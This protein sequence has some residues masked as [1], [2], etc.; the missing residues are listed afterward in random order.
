MM[1]IFVGF[2]VLTLCLTFF[3]CI[4]MSEILTAYTRIKAF[5]SLMWLSVRLFVK[6]LNLRKIMNKLKPKLRE[7]LDG[8]N[9]V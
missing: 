8:S 9:M 7:V 6:K 5:L 2:L 3:I 1:N 4:D